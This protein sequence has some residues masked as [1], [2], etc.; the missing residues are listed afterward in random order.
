MALGKGPLAKLV[1]IKNRGQKWPRTGEGGGGVGALVLCT[2]ILGNTF[3]FFLCE[4]RN[5]RCDITSSSPNGP[6]LRLFRL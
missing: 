3:K 6:L 1:K 5:P 4:T 2:L